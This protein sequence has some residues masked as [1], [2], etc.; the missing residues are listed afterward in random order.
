MKRWYQS[1][2]V[3]NAILTYVIALSGILYNAYEKENFSQADLGLILGVTYTL[4]ETIKG[5]V[6]ATEPLGKDTPQK[7]REPAPV[8]TEPNII[9][10][11]NT[12]ET[13]EDTDQEGELSIDLLEV[14]Q[15]PYKVRILRKTKIKTSDNDSSLLSL[16]DYKELEEGETFGITSWSFIKM[17]NHIKVFLEDPDEPFYLYVPDVKLLNSKGQEVS[18]EGADPD[19]VSTSKTLLR[20]PGYQSNFYLEDS[21]LPNGHFFWREATKDGTRIP[22]NKMVVENILMIA[23]ELEEVRKQLG[24][25]PIIITSWYRPPAVNRAVGGASRSQHLLGNAV[26][27]V[28]NGLTASQ[29]QAKI[30]PMWKGGVGLAT[31][32]THLDLGLKRVFGY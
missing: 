6:V 7:E 9:L 27:I 4:K 8:K 20:L 30:R 1:K 13:V 21:I 31:R 32:F 22:E 28:V 29:V 3:Q 2:T 23:S 15:R 26:D 24:N 25:R 12:L 18:I 17:S 10:V 16:K 19:F 11:E 5:R 14:L